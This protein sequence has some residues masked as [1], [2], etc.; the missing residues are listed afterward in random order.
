MNFGNSHTKSTKLSS[1]VV[2]G[3]GESGVGAALLGQQRGWK[4]FVS[5]IGNIKKQYK[6]QL[7][8]AGL[9]WEEGRHS[10]AIIFQADLVVKSPGIPDN[11]SIVSRIRG[12]GIRVISEIEFAAAYTSATLIAITGTNG[13]TTTC[14]MLHH[15]LS[16]AG[17][18]AGLAGNIGSSFALQVAC[19][20][21]NLYVLELSSFQLDGIEAF[22]PHIAVVANI[23]PDH[24]DRYP[25]YDSYVASKFRI[26]KNQ[27]EEDFLLYDAD[28]ESICSW[29][30]KF[31]IKSKLLP[32]SVHKQLDMG[33]SF[34]DDQLNINIENTSTTMASSSM[35]QKGEHH[36]KNAMAA[37]TVAKLL[38]IRKH[39]IR[40]S[41]E[42]FQG[43]E[44]RLEKVLK[45]NNVQYIN[46]SKATN[47]NATYYALESM[48]NEV[49]WIAGGVD[50]GN[51]YSELFSVVNSRVK[52]IICL[53]VDNSRLLRAFDS[54]VDLIIESSSMQD[55]VT[56]AHAIAEKGNTVLLS[57][58]CAS[59]DLFESYEDRGRQFKDAVRKL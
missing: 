22:R 36:T 35:T 3:G 41:L 34:K 14:S 31:P 47:I 20:E 5:D 45:I 38:Q 30:K 25:N 2:L 56:R 58:A 51:D 44:H 15:I 6:D 18:D 42:S 21:H 12:Q 7:D 1:L 43:V 37:A 28:N 8:T 16:Q 32:F 55:A 29:L 23:S 9:K 13:K 17:I 52:A 26:I 11:T 39:T 57:P 19:S 50:K 33:A 59:Y 49:V 10:E 53:G 46:D 40:E 27:T 48:D 4:V 54:C 24:L